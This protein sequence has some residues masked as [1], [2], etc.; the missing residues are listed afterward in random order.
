MPGS[1]KLG[2]LL[3]AFVALGLR[4]SVVWLLATE[5]KGPLTYEHGEIAKHLIAGEGFSV[6]FL[7][8]KGPTSQ[9]AP[10]YPVLLAGAYSIFGAD[11]PAALLAV[12]LLQ[13]VA[14]TALVLCVAWL[15]WSLI[16]NR[17]GIGWTAAWGAALY[18]THVYMITHMQVGVWAALELVLLL[19]VIAEPRRNGSLLRA[20][21]AGLIA[22]LLLLTEPILALALPVA[23]VML[24]RRER[25]SSLRTRLSHWTSPRN[26]FRH[27]SPYLARVLCMASVAVIVIAPWLWRNYRVH[28]EFVFIKS[29]FGYAFWQGNNSLSWGTDKIPRPVA[30]TLRQQHDGTLADMDR[31]LW[32]ARHKTLY[33]DDM[34]LTKDDYRELASLNEPG[35]SRLLMARATEFIRDN[36]Q[37]YARLCLRRLRYFLLFDETNPKAAQRL[38]RIATVLWLTLAFIGVL[39]SRP[40]WR[41]LWPTF[42]I[43]AVVALFHTLTITSARFRIP[44]EPMT[45]VWA[46]AAVAPLAGRLLS[47]IRVST[48]VAVAS[49]AAFGPKHGLNGPHH[50]LRAHTRIPRR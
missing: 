24:W 28:G 8:G 41:S 20:V 36:P 42:A 17:P 5:H 26:I 7:G 40:Y 50:R 30:E 38:Y 23:A 12:K 47:R 3:L 16:P 27:Q 18:P 32:E 37:Q 19:A 34:A 10:F 39:A 22:G 44:L 45:F 29:T 14:G 43:F 9:Q 15:G 13:A 46:A 31:A 35:R 4:L 6:R 33:I 49:P 21:S 2:L 11:S 25:S 48:P 1:R